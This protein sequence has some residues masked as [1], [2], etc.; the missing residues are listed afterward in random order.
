MRT[1]GVT[2]TTRG[3]LSDMP[4]A[5]DATEVPEGRLVRRSNFKDQVHAL[6]RDEIVTGMLSPGT[7]YSM[8]ELATRYG[9]SRTPIREAL[10]E[11]ESKGFVRVLRGVGF[12]VVEPSPEYLRDT[13]QIREMLETRA[14]TAIAGRMSEADHERAHELMMQAH[15]VAGANDPIRYREVDRAFHLFLASLTGNARLV[16][17]IAELRDTQL[18]PGLTR[19]ASQGN[20]VER[21]TQHFALLEALK[22]G[23]ATAAAE[24]MRRHLDF[25]RSSF[26]QPE[27]PNLLDD[28]ASAPS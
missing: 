9:A 26:G 28:V 15:E 21:S 7:S 8:G 6:I 1:D 11:L 14:M 13:L 17:L 2:A 3:W 20:L 12:E 4:K 24:A 16:Q 27:H 25:S 5:V 23:N 18:M 10:I 22:N 19:I